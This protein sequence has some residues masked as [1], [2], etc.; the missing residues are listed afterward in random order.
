MSEEINLDAANAKIAE[1]EA[2]V[3]VMR[4]IIVQAMLQNNREAPA[5]QM[6]KNQMPYTTSTSVPYGQYG[7]TV[8]Q[9][10][11]QKQWLQ[12]E[13]TKAAAPIVAFSKFTEPQ[14]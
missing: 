3:R 14:A 8:G 1:L 11:A 12:D 2:Q 7:T 10:V 5:E 4:G 9:S 6:Y 13:L